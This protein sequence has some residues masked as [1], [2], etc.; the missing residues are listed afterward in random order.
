MQPLSIPNI[1]RIK[2]NSF[3]PL[4]H[5][6]TGRC[7]M[8][9]YGFPPFIDASCRREPDFQ[10]PFPSISALC[11]QGIF[12][13]HLR[14]NDVVVYMTVGGKYQNHSVVHHRIVSI[15]LVEHVYPTHQDGEIGYQALNV[16]TPSNCMVP[17][18]LPFDFDKT[19]GDFNTVRQETS[20]L[21]K[22]PAVQLQIGQRRIS[23]WD[24]A[25]LQ[26]SQTWQCFV[27]TKALYLDLHNPTPILEHQFVSIFGKVPNT[28]TP[29]IISKHELDGLCTFI[30]DKNDSAQNCF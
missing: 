16:P 8:S 2:L 15:L 19:A 12:A 7:A 13:P 18:N 22:L 10:N 20:Y 29:R 23:I 4:C 25:Y 11:R 14:H 24:S 9:T 3:H 1:G 21:S 30:Y 28:R 17:S 6:R 27:R 26:K 5:T